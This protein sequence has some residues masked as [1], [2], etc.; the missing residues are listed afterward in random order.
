MTWKEIERLRRRFERVHKR[1]IFDALMDSLKD[2]L[3][4]IN[5]GVLDILPEKIN[6]IVS[7]NS[8]KIAFY[9]LYNDVGWTFYRSFKSK[10]ALDEDVERSLWDMTFE[11]V[12]EQETGMR[13]TLI[14]DYTKEI[15]QNISREVLLQGQQE[16]LGILEMERIL[17]RRL[18]SEF[19]QMARYR[20][21]RIVQT[22]TMS[23]S[24]FATLQAGSHSGIQM[25]KVWLTAPVGVAKTERHTEYEPGLGQQRPA[26][27]QD[28]ILGSY[29]MAYPGDPKGGPEN[30]I[31][32]RCALSWEP[33]EMIL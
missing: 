12:I 11:K 23:A 17:R 6:T 5:P 8:L 26:K 10:K 31:N 4:E 3:K 7:N 33:I 1:K 21:L 19:T 28:F 25:R 22:E 14:T 29:R 27:G 32:C 30:V 15:L 20:S 9:N 24:N 16:G 18:S 13:I 2:V